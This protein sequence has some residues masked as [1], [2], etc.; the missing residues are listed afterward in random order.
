VGVINKFSPQSLYW[1]LIAAVAIGVLFIQGV[2]AVGGYYAQ[3]KGAQTQ[4]AFMLRERVF[5]IADRLEERGQNWDAASLPAKKRSNGQISIIITPHALVLPGYSEDA[6]FTL[7]ARQ[8]L[9]TARVGGLENISVSMGPVSALPKALSDPPLRSRFVRRLLNQGAGIPSKAVMLTAQTNDGRWVS[10]A[11]LVRPAGKWA[12]VMQLVK[13]LAIFAAVMIPLA[14]V[15]RRI[16]RPLERLT[17]Q[18]ARVGIIDEA[19]PLESKGP[20]D[21]RNLIDSFNDMQAR[22]TSLL[23][24][25]DVMLGAIGHDL[26]TPLASLRVRVESVED[27]IEREKMAATIDEIVMILDDILTLARLGKSGEPLQR[28]DIGALLESVIEDFEG[29]VEMIDMVPLSAR[30]IANIRPVLI[31]RALRNLIGNAIKHGGSAVLSVQQ[32]AGKI[33]INID[34]NG[35]GIPADQIEN[36][37]T[38]FVRTD[39]SRNRATGGSGLGLTIARAI[40]RSH[41]GEVMLTN[42]IEGGL[43]AVMTLADK[44]A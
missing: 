39:A 23:G 25:K 5:N 2:S 28:T 35:P 43:R 7:A 29:A 34:D 11:S 33:H 40:A 16:V 15:A 4:A 22:V 41:N 6:E 38:P 21:I 18:A 20:A 26:K 12:L 37:F 19:S 24:E 8:L 3:S 13:A 1:Q 30:V 44:E 32:S 31:R 10:S 42:R 17:E 9:Q 27:D 36:M 14:L